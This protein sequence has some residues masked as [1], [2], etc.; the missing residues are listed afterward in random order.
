MATEWVRVSRVGTP[1]FS[2]DD[3]TPWEKN[4]KIRFEVAP[5][6]PE[7]WFAL[8]HEK[9]GAAGEIPGQINTSEP[10]RSIYSGYVSSSKEGIGDTIAKLDAIIDDTNDRFEAFQEEAA[11]AQ[12]ANRERADAERAK[13]IEE[14][15]E[16]D[17]LAESFAKPPYQPE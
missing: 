5:K 13:R 2:K 6:P 15:D 14:Q 17:A 12:A 1:K 8:F 11:A 16:L 10:H 3:S 9:V 4:I 7:K